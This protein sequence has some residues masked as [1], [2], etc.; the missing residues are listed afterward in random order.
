MEVV[1][2]LSCPSEAQENPICQDHRFQVFPIQGD[3]GDTPA[4]CM[5]FPRYRGDV[6]DATATCMGG[7]PESFV[8]S[9]L[10]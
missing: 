10:P 4:T 7:S 9:G 6:G 2:K 3:V 8:N 5:N 1:N